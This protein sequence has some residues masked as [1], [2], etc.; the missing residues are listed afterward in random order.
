M[1]T[2]GVSWEDYERS[3]QGTRGP[4][5]YLPT[6]GVSM[7]RKLRAPPKFIDPRFDIP[8][9]EQAFAAA[10]PNVY[11]AGKVFSEMF[12]KP[13]RRVLFPT[14]GELE[15]SFNELN[16]HIPFTKYI[17]PGRREEFLALDQ[18]EQTRALLWDTLETMILGVPKTVPWFFKGVAKTVALPI[19]G[20][21]AVI[22]A[23]KFAP[24]ED[25]L[26][27]G[28]RPF[29]REENVLRVLKKEGWKTDEVAAILDSDNLYPFLRGKTRKEAGKLSKAFKEAIDWSSGFPRLGKETKEL[30]RTDL[31]RRGHF[32]REWNVAF[33]KYAKETV[34]REVGKKIGKK[35]S[36]QARKELKKELRKKIGANLAK[37]AFDAQIGQALGA[38]LVGKITLKNAPDVFMAN[39]TRD[40]FKGS[41]VVQAT[42]RQG[43]YE[44]I[45]WD[46]FNPVRVAFGAWERLYGTYK[47]V[48][49]KVGPGLERR[50]EYVAE[51]HLTLFQM[52]KDRGIGTWTRSASGAI[53][54]VPAYG[55]KELKQAYEGLLQMDN[56]LELGRRTPQLMEKMRAQAKVIGDSLPETPGKIVKVWRDYSDH[57]FAEYVL[58]KTPQLFQGVGLT[59]SGERA[60]G[61][62][63][64]KMGPLLGKIFAKEAGHSYELKS[65]AI[66]RILEEVRR[67]LAH[68]LVKKEGK[69]PW[70]FLEGVEL[71]TALARLGKNLTQGKDGNF[72]G[73]LEDYVAR[74][75]ASGQAMMKRWDTAL[76]GKMHPFYEKGRKM[77]TPLNLVEDMGSMMEVRTRTQANDLFLYPMIEEAVAHSKGLPTHVREY[78]DHYI[79]RILGR[80]ASMDTKTANFLRKTIG[81]LG[82]RAYWTEEKVGMLG[83]RLNDLALMG[84][85]GFKPFAA[86]RDLF[87][88]LLTVPADL[89]GLKG[90]LHLFHG[91]RR[92]MFDPQARKY[93]RDIGAIQEFAPELYLT[94]R[95]YSFGKDARWDQVRDVS[96]Y[97]YGFT[98]RFNRYIAGGAALNKWEGMIEKIGVGKL[99]SERGRKE[100]SRKMFRERYPWVREELDDLLRLGRTEEAKALWTNDV[101]ADTQFLYRPTESPIV[102]QKFGAVGRT[103]FLFQSWWQNYGTLLEKWMRTGDAGTK[104]NKMFTWMTSSAA[105]MTMMDAAWGPGTALRN[106]FFG[107]FPTTF[108]KTLIPAAWTPLYE[109][110]HLLAWGVPYHILTGEPE[111][112]EEHVKAMIKSVAI[113]F[114]G[115]LQIKQ[116]AGAVTR[117]GFRGLPASV[118]R[119]QRARDWEPLAV[120]TFKG[121][122]GIVR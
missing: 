17:D 72:V 96:L 74:V 2:V 41:K 61:R 57:L 67:G 27:K 76:L 24:I 86:L 8:E 83:R 1:G 53:D 107:P 70:F 81:N 52:H 6:Q 97:L 116:M 113:L 13:A 82:G 112:L 60:L 115:G 22:P 94:Q 73:Y 66:K 11:S 9:E 51:K 64:E 88:P 85:L 117:E 14:P 15:D 111:K 18:Q 106:T 38:D 40:I 42:L 20:V 80:Q 3:K 84:G 58:E 121:I 49:K 63:M 118:V 21:K 25:L 91:Y 19:K 36:P 69:H 108:D 77:V 47:G 12:L 65:K 90:F 5:G 93:I 29:V 50:N 23:Y 37:D 99:A 4:R 68:P 39:F 92:A 46:G 16:K 26:L 89:G 120:R 45:M 103:G 48:Y 75:G 98:D 44:K 62:T 30:L 100:F 43:V 87:Q 59:A 56:L 7:K 119:Y 71:K 105:T 54:F 55:A 31:L 33:S 32:R 101:I 122:E 102:S 35:I 78:V 104:A 109:A 114:P 79:S 10:W 95:I 110:G 34:E 28:V